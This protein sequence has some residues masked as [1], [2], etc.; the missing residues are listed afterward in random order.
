MN[1][2]HFKR[3]ESANLA[4]WQSNLRQYAKIYLSTTRNSKLAADPKDERITASPKA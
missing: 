3:N 1:R 2:S 4:H